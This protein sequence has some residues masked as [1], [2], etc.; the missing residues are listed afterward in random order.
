MNHPL[1]GAVWKISTPKK[2]FPKPRDSHEFEI[3]F[4]RGEWIILSGKRPEAG[5]YGQFFATS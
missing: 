3:F 2:K 1:G 4:D 5:R